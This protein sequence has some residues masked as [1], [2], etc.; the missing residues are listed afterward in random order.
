MSSLGKRDSRDVV[1]TWQEL[2]AN[3][4]SIPEWVFSG[5]KTW[6]IAALASLAATISPISS[7]QA[8]PIQ[9]PALS[10]ELKPWTNPLLTNIALNNWVNYDVP[11]D[12]SILSHWLQKSLREVSDRFKQWEKDWILTIESLWNPKLRTW[13]KWPQ[14]L[15]KRIPFIAGKE[16][17]TWNF[18]V[19]T[20][21]NLDEVLRDM[22]TNLWKLSAN[23]LKWTLTW[24]FI[25]AMFEPMIKED[26]KMVKTME[27]TFKNFSW[28]KWWAFWINEWI[29][30]WKAYEVVITEFE[31]MV[32]VMQQ[33]WILTPDT[34]YY[35]FSDAW[36]IAYQTSLRYKEVNWKPE[37]TWK[38]CDPSAPKEKYDYCVDTV[39]TWMN[40]W[41]DWRRNLATAVANRDL[42]TK[43]ELEALV[44]SHVV[45]FKDGKRYE[46][47]TLVPKSNQELWSQA[48]SYW[49]L[50][51]RSTF[52]DLVKTVES[53]NRSAQ[54]DKDIAESKERWAAY[55]KSWEENVRQ[56]IAIANWKLP[57]E[58][59]K[60]KLPKII[61]A[62]NSY[63]KA[64]AN[65]ELLAELDAAILKIDSRAKE[66]FIQVVQR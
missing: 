50:A 7:A 18:E 38:L 51:D 8:S 64:W 5:V 33:R 27:S 31:W 28:D 37:F 20:W 46:F 53:K 4:S 16:I 26:P 6:V 49:I 25:Q 19:L 32:R 45:T 23:E 3:K 15:W 40:M 35:A 1:S 60:P 21:F 42:V 55:M 36:W 43:P 11:L 56:F 12:S 58:E 9:R 52:N 61:I 24:R 59:L 63:V 39:K 22:K 47:Q 48:L 34:L 30:D 2:P 44:F 29:L 13:I 10:W 57:V 14:E 54:L 41:I 66:Q 62:R 65:P 17:T